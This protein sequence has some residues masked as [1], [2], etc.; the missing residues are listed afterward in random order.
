MV[1]IIIQISLEIEFYSRDKLATYLMLKLYDNDDREK[2]S[3]VP[4]WKSGK[5]LMNAHRDSIKRIQHMSNF[6]RYISI[7][8][9]CQIKQN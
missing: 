4:N 1:R 3:S 9:V 8:K 7:S 6:S 2:A 5:S